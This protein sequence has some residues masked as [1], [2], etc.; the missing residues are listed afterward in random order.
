MSQLV[1]IACRIY[2]FGSDVNPKFSYEKSELKKQAME[3]SEADYFEKIRRFCPT[4]PDLTQMPGN[5]CRQ[6]CSDEN[7]E[8][9]LTPLPDC[10]EKISFLV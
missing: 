6:Y 8:N 3:E 1:K 7:K 10:A 5:F 9:I 2:F 4:M